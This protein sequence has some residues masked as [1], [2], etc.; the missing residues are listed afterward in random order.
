MDADRRAQTVVPFAIAAVITAI[1]YFGI[2]FLGFA[3][4]V[5]IGGSA[6]VAYVVWFFTAWRRPIDPDA[7]STPYFVLI[8]MELIH[9]CEEQI[10]DF[11]G[12][13]REI[14]NIPP[15]FDR[16]SHAVLL[17]GIVNALAVLAGLGLRSKNVG[18]RLVSS[19][20]VWFY[21]IGP[22][23]VNAV[24][25][26]VFPIIAHRWYFSGLVTVILP[27]VAG[28]VSLV[29]LVENDRQTAPT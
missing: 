20:I 2:P 11:P 1:I 27:T 19:F 4:M 17:M 7:V 29:R 6:I 10:T 23:M 12:S 9:M 8:A 26:V 28:V 14:F 16:L 24:A 3:T 21:V 18:V 5:V 13:L 15:T 25:H 22:G